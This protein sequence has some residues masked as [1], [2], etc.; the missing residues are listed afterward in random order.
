M[1][2]EDEVPLL[3]LLLWR[4][5]F[6]LLNEKKF[7]MLLFGAIETIAESQLEET[8]TPAKQES[9]RIKTGR[10]HEPNWLLM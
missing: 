1:I 3:L 6:K 8:K 9:V 4:K 2:N 5:L 10:N 7:I